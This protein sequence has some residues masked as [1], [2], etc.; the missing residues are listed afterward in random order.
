MKEQRPVRRVAW[1]DDSEYEM[2]KSI[3]WMLVWEF[4]LGYYLY[5]LR[6][7]IH[8]MDLEISYSNTLPDPSLFE[9]KLRKTTQ[10]THGIFSKMKKK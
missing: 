2:S 9:A 3:I 4:V 7:S 10:L 5:E 1:M 8:K 6:T